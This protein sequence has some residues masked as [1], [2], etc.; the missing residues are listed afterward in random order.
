MRPRLLVL[1]FLAACAA[2]APPLPG[3]SAPATVEERVDPGATAPE[4]SSGLPARAAPPRT[5]RAYW[6]VFVAFAIAWVLLFGYTV[7]LGRRFARIERELE[8]MG[9]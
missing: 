4:T 9:G 1:A 5:L 8:S 7:A 3:Q 6:H 2:A